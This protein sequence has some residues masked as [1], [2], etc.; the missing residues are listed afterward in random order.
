MAICT[1]FCDSILQS[2]SQ[3]SRLHTCI[4]LESIRKC[5][6]LMLYAVQLRHCLLV[7]VH[8]MPRSIDL[9]PCLVGACLARVLG[10]KDVAHFLECFPRRLHKEE[11]D[12]ND[13]DRNPDNCSLY[14][15]IV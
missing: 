15:G 7:N 8:H 14:L 11:V 9:D 13:F 3:W 5:K 1:A 12:D 10:A 6:P 2:A 4:V